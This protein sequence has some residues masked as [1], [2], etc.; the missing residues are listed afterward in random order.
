MDD[1][2]KK[3]TT[4]ILYDNAIFFVGNDLALSPDQPTVLT[5]I[6]A[7]LAEQI[8]YEGSNRDL[9]AIAQQYEL[10][11]GRPALI[12][13]L[14]DALDTID[15]PSTV[16]YQHFADSLAPHTKIIT[17]RFDRALETALEQAHKSYIRIVGD[18]EVSFFDEARVSL[19]KIWG[20]ITRA[21]TLLITE[22]DV[23][24]FFKKLPAM[25]DVVRAFFA[26]KTLIFLGYDLDNPTFQRF[27]RQITDNLNAS[28]RREAY[29]IVPTAVSEIKQRSWQQNNV[30]IHQVE[31]VPFLEALAQSVH[32][33][34]ADHD[35]GA[36][37]FNPLSTLANPPEPNHPYKLLDSFGHNDHAIFAGRRGEVN[38]LSHRILANPLTI[39]Y[40]ES[41]SGKT[42]LLQAGVAQR[43]A[44]NQ[45][46]LAVTPLA[47]GI[48]IDEALR[49][50]LLQAG[51]L[52]ELPL[53]DNETDLQAI[54]QFW[55]GQ[56]EGPIV[57]ALD[58]FEQYW[59]G[60][61]AVQQETA[62]FL[63]R[64]LLKST[65]INLRLVLAIREDFLG[66]L[67]TLA[68]VIPNILDVRF[69]LGRLET[70]AA[71]NAIETPAQLFNLHWDD[72]LVDQLLADLQA[73]YRIMPSQLQ[74]VCTQLYND[75]QTRQSPLISLERYEE[76]GGAEAILG[77]YIDQ[78]LQ[79]LPVNEQDTARL[80]LAALVSSEQVKVRLPLAD[81]LLAA[82]TD[83]AVAEPILDFLTQKRLVQRYETTQGWEFE[84]THDYLARRIADWLG[85]EFWDAQRVRELLRTAVP[86]WNDP[87]QRR[88]LSPGEL[89]MVN[90]QRGQINF[91]EAEKAFIFA[92]AAA[93]NLSPDVWQTDL[94][95]TAVCE[96]LLIV[97]HKPEGFIR[98]NC[99]H[100]LATCTEPE[101]VTRLT[102][103]IL[104][105]EAE[106]VR[107]T[108]VMAV[109][110]TNNS[111]VIAELVEAT[112]QQETALAA[113]MALVT[114]RDR[115]TAVHDQLPATL[116]KKIQRKVWRQRW[117][118]NR[119]NILS[120]TLRG[121]VGGFLG[122]GLGFAFAAFIS[123]S[124]SLIP[125][126][127][128][129]WPIALQVVLGSIVLGG[130]VTMWGP[131][132]GAFVKA[133]ITAVSDNQQN[134]WLWLATSLSTGLVLGGF[135]AA[136][137]SILPADPAPS[138][139]KNFVSGFWLGFVTSLVVLLPLPMPKLVRL[140]I[141]IM[142]AI[143][144]YRLINV[145]QL[146]FNV[147]V[148][149]LVIAGLFTGIGIFGSLYWSM[150]GV[151]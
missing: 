100:K 117:Q 59:V 108:A 140:L 111:G 148:V 109:A 68:A 124:S 65:T 18:E 130:F 101:A 147:E 128:S 34:A 45:T 23:E 87:E 17:T 70:E 49:N 11:N 146:S 38:R 52:A 43:L 96:A 137:S 95:N 7:Y 8:E 29:A 3:L 119:Q 98:Q 57:L 106:Q 71:R 55:H 42:S 40:G 120:Y 60:L 74:I 67:Q 69:R 47:R 77:N 133:S 97:S 113:E 64:T 28:F 75:A 116:Q 103:L 82:E 56:F 50:N 33:A 149:Y 107:E 135:I 22:E 76:L 44:Q 5:Q 134:R 115:Q 145:L 150:E 58:Q 35:F 85:N 20:D 51:T 16:L 36:P 84:L 99:V 144:N 92:S 27:F 39:L 93:Y 10:F 123:P 72:K 143:L 136:L 61:D 126:F 4:L 73:D 79:E 78:V 129:S 14:K 1:L 112:R 41:G 151:K 104:Q 142:V 118:R 83:T 94:N 62:V 2:I 90:N 32:A 139:L 21:K 122:V 12:Q 127:R 81:L 125:I 89:R 131:V 48:A 80:L 30:R 46:L 88:L 132:A 121:L 102:E 91:T 26:T 25:N 138:I 31:I 110:D 13:A 53:P 63:I 114:M 66:R 54:L 141:T 6:G 9:A 15:D 105:D 37:P 19:I 24:K 86:E